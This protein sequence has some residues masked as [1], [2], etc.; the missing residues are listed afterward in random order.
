MQCLATLRGAALLCLSLAPGAAALEPGVESAGVELGPRPYYLVDQHDNKRTHGDIR[1]LSWIHAARDWEL[2]VGFSKVFWGVTE[3]VHLVDIINQT[4]YVV[5]DDGEDK[6][7]Q[8][9]ANLAL[10]RDW[11]VL[12]LFVL[13]YFRDRTFHGKQ[14]RPRF[15]IPV[16][17][18]HIQYE[19]SSKQKHVDFA[20][21]WSHTI[22]DWDIGLAHFTGTSRE[23]RFVFLP[24]NINP[25]TLLPN[26][27]NQLYEQI[28]Q[29][30]IDLQ[31]TIGSWLWKLEA[32]TRSGQGDRFT[33]AAGG[34]PAPGGRPCSRR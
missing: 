31:A 20:V 30:S 26:A 2:T 17:N 14:G 8:P 6:L 24:K 29:T 25:V 16:D 12:D 22:G 7:G 13:P 27:T 21:R 23:P 3:A 33:A 34:P 11:G 19:S 28:H 32:F 5:N 10:I 15:G 4:D 18:N 9:M 1:E